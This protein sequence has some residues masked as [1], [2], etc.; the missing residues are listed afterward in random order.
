MTDGQSAS[1]SRNK[2]PNWSLRPDLYYCMTIAGLLKSQFAFPYSLISSQHRPH[3]ENSPHIVAWRRPHRKHVSRVRLQVH[4]SVT[5]TG[6]DVD[7]IENTASFIVAC[8]T[9]FTELLPGNMLIKSVIVPKVSFT[10]GQLWICYC[11]LFFTCSS[12]LALLGHT[13]IKQTRKL[14]FTCWLSVFYCSV[15][16]E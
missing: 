8:W 3:T 16:S 12:L 4:L 11:F 2:A 6:H 9:T 1:L 10:C 5:S 7:N 14:L 15:Q 13:F